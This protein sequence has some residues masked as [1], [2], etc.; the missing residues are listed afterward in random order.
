MQVVVVPQVGEEHERR[1][2]GA[3]I[4]QHLTGAGLCRGQGAGS[5]RPSPPWAKKGTSSIVPRRSSS[6]DPPPRC[7]GQEM[8]NAVS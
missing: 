6:T 2:L 3:Q 4:G 5:D 1:R 8:K 7:S